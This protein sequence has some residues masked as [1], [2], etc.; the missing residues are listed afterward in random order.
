MKRMYHSSGAAVR[1][2]ALYLITVSLSFSGA[3]LPEQVFGQ[4]TAPASQKAS[5]PTN[6]SKEEKSKS[7]VLEEVVVTGSLIRNI[8]PVGANVIGTSREDIDSSGTTDSNQLLGTLPQSN[9]FLAFQNP[10]QGV[11][12]GVSRVPINTPNLRNLPQGATGSPTTLVMLD[13]HRIVPAGIE[14]SAVDAG[15]VPSGILERVETILDGTSAVYG[16]DAAGGVINYVSR[17]RFDETKADLQYG[18]ADDYYTKAANITSGTTWDGGGVGFTYSFGMN[19]PLF[20]KDRDYAG[21]EMQALVASWLA[22][23][24]A[25]VVHVVR[26]HPWVTPVLPR[27]QWAA[28]AAAA[29]LPVARRVISTS[30]HVRQSSS[31][32]LVHEKR[33][34][35]GIG[36]VT[37]DGLGSTV[38][39]AGDGTGGRLA[40]ALGAGCMR[41]A[42]TLGF[43]LLEFRFATEGERTVLTEVDPLPSLVE[44]WATALTVDLLESRAGEPR[45]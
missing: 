42:R 31:H 12:A 17:K 37:A 7:Q 18:F 23:F 28:A 8:A 35:D 19:S 20:A 36:E 38:L 43:P 34:E 27:Q 6:A 22:G 1:R 2:R 25:R 14:Q 11:L 16:S 44:P 4:Q 5:E 40:S 45:S 24:G 9:F 13:G 10:G 32:G 21:A 26:Q 3:I 41:A 30:P 15:I 33:D 39:V 29:G